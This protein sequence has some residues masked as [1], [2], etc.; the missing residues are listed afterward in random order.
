M[1]DQEILENAPE[2]NVTSIQITS[3]GDV[4]RW[5]DEI[6]R[7]LADVKRIAELEKERDDYKTGNIEAKEFIQAH[8]RDPLTGHEYPRKAY[9]PMTEL[10]IRDLR[11]QAK[12]IHDLFRKHYHPDLSATGLKIW[13][14][15]EELMLLNKADE[16]EQGE[17]E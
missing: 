4:L 2:G 6:W 5:S 3:K 15:K 17:C 16:L 8:I 1:N 7:S 9:C 14:G 10:A 13:A 12:G 11:Q